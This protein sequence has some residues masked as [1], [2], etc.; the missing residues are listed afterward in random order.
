MPKKYP[1]FRTSDNIIDEMLRVWDDPDIAQTI[2]SLQKR[3]NIK[4]STTVKGILVA[5]GRKTD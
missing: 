5:N 4:C 3:F 1:E 2:H